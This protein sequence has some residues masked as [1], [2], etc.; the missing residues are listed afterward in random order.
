VVGQENAILQ[1]PCNWG[2]LPWQPFLAFYM[3]GALP[4]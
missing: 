2:P 4:T 3:R 1:I